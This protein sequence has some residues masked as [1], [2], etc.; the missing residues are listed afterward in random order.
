MDRSFKERLEK[1][2][3]G[4]LDG[5]KILE[6][7]YIEAHDL[8][9]AWFQCLYKLLDLGYVYPITKGSYEHDQH[10]LE[11]DYATIRIKHPEIRPL[12]PQMPENSTVPPPT[13][14]DKIETYFARYLFSDE[15]TGKE[16]YTYGE[17]LIISVE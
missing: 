17:R 16:Q 10:R 13:N 1:I 15:K 11:F 6:P 7:V 3:E 4:A 8:G 2:G 12:A 9:D 5:R 14:D